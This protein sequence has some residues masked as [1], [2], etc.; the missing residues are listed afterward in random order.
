MLNPGVVLNRDPGVHL[1][2]LKST[3]AIEEEATACVECGLCE[4][5]CP[6]RHTTT[7]PRQRI[8]LRREMARQDEGSPVY[9]ALL[10]DYEHEAIQTCAADGSCQPVC[11]V[12]IDTGKLMK[13]FRERE[14]TARE[15]RVA[16]AVA[17]R[18]GA[19][20]RLARAGLRAGDVIGDDAA[21]AAPE[22]LRKRVSAELVPTWPD[23]MP[24]AAPGRLP[25]TS[26]GAAAA[27]YMPA[28][29]NRI[30]GNPRGHDASLTLPEALVTVSARAG[31][32]LWIP[33]DAGG[34]CCATPW[35]SKGY[36]QGEEFMTAKVADS[37]R[38]W[39]KDGT[40]PVVID[41]ASCSHALAEACEGVEVIDSV[42]WAHDHL[43]PALDVKRKLGS[44]AV[45]PTCSTT[46][47]GLRGKLEG[48]AAA[49]AEEVVVP[50]GTTCCGMAGDRGLLHP[51]LPPSAL[52]DQAAQLEGRDL[53]ACVCSNRTCE[54][55]L[56]QVTGRAYGSFVFELERLTR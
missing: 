44:M 43:L 20:E 45:H 5:V 18:Y 41:A 32:P 42:E 26:R 33:P 38:R 55:A 12:A 14:R 6:S 25:V 11:P 27:V 51:E 1:N 54:L 22:F 3:P 48:V 40:L 36:K 34:N 35:S 10:A 49:L 47:M 8:V 39:T 19:V 21:S 13:V 16:L 52:R 53:D 23:D 31:K 30:F 4:P 2:N 15:E 37:L 9:E 50:I 29:I 24:P 56:Q 17:K 28:C 46:H 7:T